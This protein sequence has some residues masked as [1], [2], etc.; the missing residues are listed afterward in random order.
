MIV[1]TLPEELYDK[2]IRS[3]LKQTSKANNWTEMRP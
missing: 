2:E 3:Q 1:L